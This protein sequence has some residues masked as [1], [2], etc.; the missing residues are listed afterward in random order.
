MAKSTQNQ[1]FSTLL[2][3]CRNVLKIDLSDMESNLCAKVGKKLPVVLTPVE[4]KK[5]LALVSGTNGLIFHLIYSTGLR[6]SEC[7][8]LRVQGS[9]F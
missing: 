7:G 3:L 5:L 6:L 2:F 8:R 4:T 9:G 1:A